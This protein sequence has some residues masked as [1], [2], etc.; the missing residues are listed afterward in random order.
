MSE[1][2]ATPESAL[3]ST[4]TA[5]A[6]PPEPTAAF[7]APPHDS[8]APPLA[9]VAPT[10]TRPKSRGWIGVL[11]GFVVLGLLV[12]ANVVLFTRVQDAQDRADEAVTLAGGQDEIEARL[13]DLDARLASVES[14]SAATADDIDAVRIQVT[15]LRKCVN[16]ALD[17]FAQATQSGKPVSITKC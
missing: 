17:S 7:S 11:V 1:T 2:P 4:A 10:S 3:A 16:A 6:A 5:P 14:S 12:G 15:A 8:T 13:G 9:P